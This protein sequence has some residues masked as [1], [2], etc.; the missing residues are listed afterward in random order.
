MCTCSSWTHACTSHSLFV[1]RSSRHKEASGS[2]SRR[3]S[4]QEETPALSV[5]ERINQIEAGKAATG[6]AA[7][8]WDSAGDKPKKKKPTN[9]A[10]EEFESSGIMISFV[11][12][13]L[14]S[15]LDLFIQV[16]NSCLN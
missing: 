16:M 4:S 6:T 14:Y 7:P 1:A 10:F 11:R 2:L 3:D 15:Y 12:N 5:K 8:T 13:I 9:Q